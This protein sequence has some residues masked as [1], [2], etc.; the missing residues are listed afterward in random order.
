MSRTRAAAVAV[1]AGAVLLAGAAPTVAATTP[2]PAAA[3]AA[4]LKKFTN[5]A[6]LNRVYK[7]GVGRKGA[8]DK[9][10]SKPVKT[11]RVDN[12]LYAALPKNLDR[13]RD[14]IACE[15]H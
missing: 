11:F 10:K 6:A 7:H 15:K 12:R 1:C 4:P 14:G 5:C 13:D 8:V 2:D 9:T 3:T